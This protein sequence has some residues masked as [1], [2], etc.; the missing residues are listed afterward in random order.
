MLLDRTIVWS[1]FD[2]DNKLAEALVNRGV[3]PAGT[4]VQAVHMAMGLGSVNNVEVM[5]GFS[6][7]QT[8]IR[9][10]GQV[11]FTL[12]NLRDGASTVVLAPAIQDID[13]MD[14][15][16][17]ANVYDITPEGGKVVLGKRRGRKPK[18]RN[19]EIL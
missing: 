17:F 19:P 4:E 18:N 2:M 10:D 3:L 14:P 15:V 13:G 6:I 11:V 1:R 9:S 16:R 7:T 8:K 12:A 5:S